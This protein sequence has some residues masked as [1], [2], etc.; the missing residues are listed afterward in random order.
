MKIRYKKIIVW[1]K[2]DKV[3]WNCGRRPNERGTIIATP[4]G[5]DY[6]YPACRFGVK[7]DSGGTDYILENWLKPYKTGGRITNGKTK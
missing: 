2:G 5:P 6:P 4:Y 7:L 1:E 3:Y